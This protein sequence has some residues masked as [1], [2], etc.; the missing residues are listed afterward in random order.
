MRSPP[1]ALGP[2]FIRKPLSL[3]EKLP[4]RSFFD[5]YT[6]HHHLRAVAAQGVVAGVFLLNEYVARKSLGAGRLHI[7][8]LLLLPAFAQ[9]VAVAWNP[10]DPR[11]LLGRRPFRLLGI[12]SRLLL[13]LLLVP[14]LERATPFV[15][16]V[17]AT[18]VAESLLMPVQNWTL[19]RNYATATRGRR[20]GAATALNALVVM[21]VVMPAGW[22]LDHDANAWPLLY[23]LAAAAG[24]YQYLH[25]SRRR[26]RAR[27]VPES[28]RTTHASPWQTL[29]RDREFLAFEGCFM[30][31][32]LG[33]LMLQPVLPL[34]LVDELHVS[35]TQVGL[36][37][38]VLFYLGITLASLVMGRLADRIGIL[39][40]GALSFLA[41]T[42][43]PLALLFLHGTAALYVGFGAYGLAMGGVAVAWNIGPIAIA[44]ERDPL[45]YLN[46][47]VALVGVRAVVG[48]VLGSWLQYR[49]GSRPVFWCVVG[50]E[51]M[52]AFAMYR[53]AR[54]W[55][56]RV[57]GEAAA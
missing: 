22:A 21:A 50:L 18:S 37:R 43:F 30:V 27:H 24:V 35:Y 33:F 34:Y 28:P 38:G 26:R 4:A 54:T 44:R 23:A 20:F 41:L 13:L 14:F 31:Y 1:A 6:A 9:F 15:L 57:D 12:P 17:G 8:A 45:P 48:M 10:T 53:M 2:G 47:H 52:A 5:A 42:S 55:R 51:I 39:R 36:A 32:G 3:S 29:L 49:V 11:R 40:I 19:A 16:L 56:G 25:W 7:L 46:A